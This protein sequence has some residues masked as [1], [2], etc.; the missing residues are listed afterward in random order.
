MTA[1]LPT[2]FVTVISIQYR[3]LKLLG[4]YYYYYYSF[5][6]ENFVDLGFKNV[7]TKMNKEEVGG[8]DSHKCKVKWKWCESVGII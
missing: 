7:M 8:D 5:F 6:K 1:G 2:Q 4:N 3:A